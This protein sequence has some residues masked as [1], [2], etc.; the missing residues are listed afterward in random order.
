MRNII[1]LVAIVIMYVRTAES[2]K[3][4]NLQNLQELHK[5]NAIVYS[6]FYAPWC[7]H[8]KKLKPI[9]Q[10]VAKDISSA[11]V[12]VTMI[13]C[14]KETSP[15]GGNTCSSRY[16]IKGYP[17]IRMFR[18][19]GTLQYD[20]NG[21][22][23]KKDITNWIYD[24]SAKDCLDD[25]NLCTSDEINTLKEVNNLTLDPLRDRLEQLKNATLQ[26]EEWFKTEVQKLQSRFEELTKEKDS[27]SR[28]I[29]NPVTT[30]MLLRRKMTL[31]TEHVE[32]QDL[33]QEEISL[34]GKKAPEKKEDLQLD[35][36]NPKEEKK[37]EQNE[38]LQKEKDDI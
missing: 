18:H 3:D 22:R 28:N 29:S 17:T 24:T 19:H 33:P 4:I 2:A 37:S 21:N 32:K 38:N 25:T 6:M 13:D 5:S 34:K 26:V 16:N 1:A 36:E 30:A 27:K 10:D 8:C 9:W 11:S 20:Y 31:E 14:T 15:N 12:V 23:T 7:G 35:D